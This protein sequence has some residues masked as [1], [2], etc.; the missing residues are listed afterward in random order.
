MRSVIITVEVNEYW[1]TEQRKRGDAPFEQIKEA[2]LQ[3]FSMLHIVEKSKKLEISN[4]PSSQNMQV[5][6]YIKSFFATEYDMYI[7]EGDFKLTARVY[8]SYEKPEEETES[9]TETE[10]ELEMKS[11]AETES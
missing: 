6:E 1:L 8:N 11:R 10:S 2:L 9:K 3:K 4:V 5:R 7:Q